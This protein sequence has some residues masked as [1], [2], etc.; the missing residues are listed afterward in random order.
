VDFGGGSDQVQISSG[1]LFHAG[2]MLGHNSKQL[3]ISVQGVQQ[4]QRALAPNG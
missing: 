4:G 1:R 2:I 3:F